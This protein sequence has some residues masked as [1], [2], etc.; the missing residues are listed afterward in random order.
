MVQ[1][2]PV[3]TRK[4][5][6]FKGFSLS[7]FFLDDVSSQNIVSVLDTTVENSLNLIL[8]VR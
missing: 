1:E 5:V 7:D 8:Y 6:V 4:N 2:R 3:Q